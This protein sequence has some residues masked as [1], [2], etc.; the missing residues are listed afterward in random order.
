MQRKP[1]AAAAAAANNRGSGS[2]RSRRRG[3]QLSDEEEEE[4][5][6]DSGASA[7]SAGHRGDESDSGSGGGSASGSDRTSRAK[8]RR[9][10]HQPS[11][12]I[13]R[14]I[15]P[16]V[17]RWAAASMPSVPPDLSGVATVQAA[18]ADSWRVSNP[19]R[20][21][22]GGAGGRRRRRLRRCRTRTAPCCTAATKTASTRLFAGAC[23]LPPFLRATTLRHVGARLR[24]TIADLQTCA[25]CMRLKM[26]KLWQCWGGV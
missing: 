24:V 17:V 11:R 21:L 3:A 4:E 8:R 5:D 16:S 22:G 7:D 23:P 1:A 19:H 20:L 15:R 10:P 9:A 12:H 2:G 26:W 14:P 13:Y 6:F 18:P 25:F